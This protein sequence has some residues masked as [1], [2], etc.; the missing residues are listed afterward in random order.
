M[1]YI[2]F[3]TV[4]WTDTSFPLMA[5]AILKSIADKANKSSVTI[6]LNLQAIQFVESADHKQEVIDFFRTGKA[7]DQI[8]DQMHNLFCSFAKIILAHKPRIVG[9]S[10][11]TY[12]CQASAQYLALVIK[13]LSPDTK[14]I[15][16]GSGLSVNFGS[17]VSFAQTL[18]TN[19]LVDYFITGDGEAALYE[20][21]TKSN[22]I[23]SGLNNDSWQQLTN[24]DL[25]EL[26]VPN[27]DDYDLSQ[28][29]TRN[30]QLVV[31]ILGSRGCVRSC[32]FCDVHTH[33]KKFTWRG[34][35]HIFNEMLVLKQKYPTRFFMFQDSLVNGNLKEYRVLTK[36]LSDHNNSV[37]SNE[38]LSWGSFFI[39]RPITQF[40][41]HDWKIT[42]ESGAITLAIGIET[43]NDDARFH[44]GKKFTNHDIEIALQMAKKY[45]I[46]LTLLFFTGYVTETDSDNDFAVQWFEDH[47]EYKEWLAINLGTPLGITPNTPLHD[48]FELLNLVRT[49]PD[50]E[51]WSNPSIN[52]TPAQRIRWHLRLQE[53]VS[54]LGYRQLGGSDQRYIFE[55][56]MREAANAQ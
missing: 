22:N 11:F 25:V 53:T 51:D 46:K 35:E 5:P 32:S 48:N 1:K 42:A 7:T 31:P 14:I 13:N 23:V 40:S 33:W 19:K 37:P 54:R 2:V 55:R 28:Y 36:L 41:E 18:L 8:Q 20:Y 21:L 56:M 4:P 44:L 15:I 10:V 26:P 27:Y 9:L 30:N 38:K 52:N 24:S 43:F 34:G 3:A 29:A 6:D 17:P 45:N 16:G 39:L 47:V 50:P 12:N 49:G